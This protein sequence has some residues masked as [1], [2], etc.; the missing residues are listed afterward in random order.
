MSSPSSTNSGKRRMRTSNPTPP[1]REDKR[2]RTD[3]MDQQYIDVSSHTAEAVHT[4]LPQ[5]T[6]SDEDIQKIADAVKS[7]IITDIT[8]LIR[9]HTEPLL[10]QI[11]QL[12]YENKKLREDVDAVEQYGRRSLIR[13]SG[14]PEPNDERNTTE[15]VRKIISDIDPEFKG[16]DILRS[17]R[18]GKLSDPDDNSDPKHRQIIVRLSEPGVKFRILKCRK[19]LKENANFKSV[20]INEDLTML[21]NNILYHCRKLLKK[22]KIKQLWATNGK[23]YMLDKHDQY[24]DVTTTTRFVQAVDKL[25][26]SYTTPDGW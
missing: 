25:D 9:S 13:I 18:V 14:V 21:R 26:P 3:V 24:Y 11:D 15:V 4:L 6:I 5:F 2:S 17:H 8:N 16:V 20:Y 1:K 22:N 23:I 7:N 19:H 12:K 10:E